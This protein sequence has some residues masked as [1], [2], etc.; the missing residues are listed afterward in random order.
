MKTDFGYLAK[1]R[2][3]NKKISA[4]KLNEN[5]VVFLGN[6]ITEGWVNTDAEF[7][8]KNNYIGRGISGQTSVQTLLRF[9]QDVL[10]LNPKAVVIQIGTNDIAEN[11]GP[12]N[13]DFTF[14]NIQ[15]MAEI[16]KANGVKVVLAS[17]LPATNFEWRR[18]LGNRSGMIVELNKR[19]KDYAM[20]NKIPY[21]DYHSAMKNEQ[22]G[23]NSDLATD[24]VHPTMKGYKIM[25]DLAEKLLISVLS[26]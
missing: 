10:S 9:R 25:E 1:Y 19:I 20:A 21:L 4:P 13:S 12:Y 22:N 16:A 17:I 5:R 18:S 3:E 26:K 2:E 23:M 24:G 6:S 7:F 11:T 15:S 8:T 14:G